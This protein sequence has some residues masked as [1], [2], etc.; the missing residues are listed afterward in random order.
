MK[1][2][3]IYTEEQKEKLWLEKLDREIRYVGGEEVSVKDNN[4][5]DYNKL[6]K[7][8]QRKNKQY[9]YGDNSKNWDLIKYE[10]QRRILNYRKRLNT[11][12]C[13]E[14]NGSMVVLQR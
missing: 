2:K 9:G 11:N 4:T 10:K 1:Q 14:T 3:K 13:S 6:L 7:Y 12:H 5:K 8:Y